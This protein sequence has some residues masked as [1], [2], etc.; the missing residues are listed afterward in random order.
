MYKAKK[1][2]RSEF[3]IWG[4]GKPLREFLYVDDLAVKYIVEN[5]IDEKLLKYWK[6]LR[7]INL[8]ASRKNKKFT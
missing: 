6:W 2:S 5:D 8:L 4:S 3:K 1:D 7:D